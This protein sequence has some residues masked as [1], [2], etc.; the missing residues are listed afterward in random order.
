[1][2]M[3]GLR[4]MHG[5]MEVNRERK[6]LG[7]GGGGKEARG[8][9]KMHG[10]SA[11]GVGTSGQMDLDDQID[12]PDLGKSGGTTKTDDDMCEDYHRSGMEEAEGSGGAHATPRRN[13]LQGWAKVIVGSQEKELEDCPKVTV[14][15]SGEEP[16]VVFPTEAYQKMEDMYRFAAVAGF[17]GGRSTTGMDYR[18]AA[19]SNQLHQD[20][21][22]GIQL[23]R[24][25]G[26]N[27][28]CNVG[29]GGESSC[30]QKEVKK[31][32][33]KQADSSAGPSRFRFTTGSK[34][35]PSV[36]ESPYI[37]TNKEGSGQ[38]SDIEGRR[39]E[40]P[41]N[42][43]RWTRNSTRLKEVDDRH[44]RFTWSNHRQGQDSVQYKLDWCL[45]NDEWQASF[46]GEG[47][48]KVQTYASSDHCALIYQN[49]ETRDEHKVLDWNKNSFGNLAENIANLQSRLE[50]CRDCVEQG[51]EG[52]LDDEYMARQ[53]L[54][55]AL[56]MEEPISEEE[57][58]TAVWSLDKDSAVGPDGF[59]NY[60]FQ[61]CWEMESP[62][63]AMAAHLGVSSSNIRI[64]DAK[65]SLV[66]SD[67]GKASFKAGEI[68][69][70]CGIQGVKESWRRKIWA[71]YA[72][73][74]SCWHSYIACEGRLPTLDRIQK[75]G[76]QLANRCSFCYCAEE[77]NVHV[78]MNCKI[79]K[80]VWKYIAAKFDRVNYPR[81]DI[82]YAFKRWIQAKIT[83]KWRRQCWRMTFL[84]VRWNLWWLKNRC[85]HDNLQPH[86][87][88][89]KKD[90]WRSCLDS[91][92]S[93]KWPA[94]IELKLRIWMETGLDS[95]DSIVSNRNG[96][97]INIV[98]ASTRYGPK[99]AGLSYA[100]NGQIGCV[101][102]INVRGSIHEGEM[103]VL[104]PILKFHKDYGGDYI[105]VS[106]IKDWV[107]KTGQRLEG[108][109][110]LT[111]WNR[112]LD[113]LQKKI[114]VEQGVATVDIGRLIMDHANATHDYFA[115][116]KM[117][118]HSL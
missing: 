4:M 106:P 101:V 104:E 41:Q 28:S 58:T 50:V 72:P 65:D 5:Q 94:E 109:R 33:A 69:N 6:E 23:D 112:Y 24:T 31:M 53:Q 11:G 77:T 17:Y 114:F 55:Q 93:V 107:M 89:F 1:M 35:N 52:A 8:Q 29:D 82:A 91:F 27:P 100:D 18:F 71:S 44:K 2:E 76:V 62:T 78:L 54:S 99:I 110:P 102:I 61:E 10:Q 7:Q 21:G 87:S 25:L 26:V 36:K 19:F 45:V 37:L 86:V 47:S 63:L 48:L 75:T 56:L 3:R 13:G 85:L 51:T 60:F 68:I 15:K 16:T 118:M 115:D 43:Q 40:T 90:V 88:R 108:R 9:R 111:S 98:R 20:E 81:G 12:F 38:A 103:K 116:L 46:G 64:R 95:V 70:N 66:W 105:I 49:R 34:D 57:V 67:D 59:P 39:G 84:I 42:R 30:Q 117:Y 73:T 22:T 113:Q 97:L 14:D 32:G 79:A 92:S 96:M 80:E 83:G 74:K